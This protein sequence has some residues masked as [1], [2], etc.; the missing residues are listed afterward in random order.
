MVNENGH[1][2]TIVNPDIRAVHD[3]MLD[4]LGQLAS[5]FGFSKVMGQLYGTLM[6]SHEPLSLDDMTERLDISKA[7][8]SMNIRTLE[9]LGMVRQAWVRGKGDRRKYYEAVTDYWQIISDLLNGREMR[10]VQR[11]IQVMRENSDK[12]IAAMPDMSGSEQDVAKVYVHRIAQLQTL[13]QFAQLMISTI[14]EQVEAIDLDD[15]ADLPT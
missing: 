15:D 13:F 8:V 2:H 5:Y 6:L 1:G 7:S 12:L 4:G 10:D 14:L 3:S 11:A 9:H